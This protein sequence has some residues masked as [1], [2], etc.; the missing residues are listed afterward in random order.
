MRAFAAH[1]LTQG[2]HSSA[3]LGPNNEVRRLWDLLGP[4]WG[5]AREI[6]ASQPFL[7]LHSA[8]LAPRTLGCGGYGP[9]SSTSSTRPA[10]RCSP[11]TGHLAETGG[12][13]RLYRSRW[14]S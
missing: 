14:L 6:R 7:T 4:D 2:R 9:T 1:A 10:S 3:I 12:G 11:T 5:P 8:P 13:A